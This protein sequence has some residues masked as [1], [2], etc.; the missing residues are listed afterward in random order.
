[1]EVV[2]AFL[3][4]QCVQGTAVC[5]RYCSVFKVL[6]CVQGQR[7]V[8][9]LRHQNGHIGVARV[10]NVSDLRQGH[11]HTYTYVNSAFSTMRNH[12]HHHHQV[13]MPCLRSNAMRVTSTTCYEGHLHHMLPAA[14]VA[15]RLLVLCLHTHRTTTMVSS[16]SS[17]VAAAAALRR[18]DNMSSHDTPD[19][20]SL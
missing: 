9:C 20:C 16:P 14:C 3:V 1:M 2:R 18:L 19:A 10:Q 6:Q 12:H 8:V 17:L 13:S 15:S 11:L 5:S 7:F 4:L